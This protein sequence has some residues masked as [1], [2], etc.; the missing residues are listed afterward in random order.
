MK[1]ILKTG[2]STVDNRFCKKIIACL[3]HIFALFSNKTF[4]L[5]SVNTENKSLFCLAYQ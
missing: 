5:P 3:L 4:F 1:N 2:K